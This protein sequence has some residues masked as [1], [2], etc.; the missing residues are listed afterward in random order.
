MAAP[1][2]FWDS[3]DNRT[4]NAITYEFLVHLLRD[5]RPW[6]ER[7]VENLSPIDEYSYSSRVSY[8]INISSDLFLEGVRTQVL[9]PEERGETSDTLRG[10]QVQLVLPLELT[11]KKLLLDFSIMDSDGKRLCLLHRSDAANLSLKKLVFNV[12]YSLLRTGDYSEAE[13]S[14]IA[15]D[16]HRLT[17]LLHALVSS[18]LD[19]ARELYG[20]ARIRH[21]RHIIECRNSS[22]WRMCKRRR[23]TATIAVVK[24]LLVYRYFTQAAHQSFVDL[25]QAHIPG[26]L[27]QI[28]VIASGIEPLTNETHHNSFYNPVIN[29]TILC[30]AFMKNEE[31]QC[32]NKGLVWD[33][34]QALA[35]VES[36]LQIAREYLNFLSTVIDPAT[37]RTNPKLFQEVY[38][39]LRDFGDHYIT[40]YKRTVTLG[41]SFLVKTEQVVPIGQRG[42]DGGRM[43][44]MQRALM[45]L[46]RRQ[47]ERV[48]YYA[49][50]L[51]QMI[52][53]RTVL[54]K[55]HLYSKFNCVGHQAFAGQAKSSHF[56]YET[57]APTEY[58]QEPNRSFVTVGRKMYSP[59]VFF[60]YASPGT[61]DRQH[62]YT[63]KSYLELLRVINAHRKGSR[64]PRRDL[65][66]FKIWIPYKLE[67]S[68]NWS[69]W[70]GTWWVIGATVIFFGSYSPVGAVGKRWPYIIPLTAAIV[71]FMMNWRAK[72]PFAADR[73]LLRR[74]TV[75]ALVLISGVYIFFSVVKPE[76]TCIV[77]AYIRGYYPVD[78][79]YLTDE[80]K[81]VQKMLE[82]CNSYRR[83]R[84]ERVNPI[85]S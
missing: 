3:L 66:D 68:L 15:A 36:F 26:L 6:V 4:R 34:G 76:R 28:A 31:Q 77:S 74:L 52:V 58:W 42:F 24:N 84:I 73:L 63:T 29:P 61:R 60:S 30:L 8:Q 83:E 64:L 51:S 17:P 54:Q 16:L 43:W 79:T 27:D 32:V 85:L 82:T 81:D 10:Q 23:L 57:T 2:E 71:A 50:V 40:Y 49:L 56:E 9:L 55:S 48:Y 45:S 39:S 7:R 14:T 53:G 19:S 11:P 69:Y 59:S 35:S 78:L 5:F 72:E 65:R 46:F 22:C 41:E 37:V 13:H 62:F 33:D 25:L 21:S 20:R 80:P 38:D 1:T 67:T 18:T 70:I 12:A 47:L 44:Q 75:L